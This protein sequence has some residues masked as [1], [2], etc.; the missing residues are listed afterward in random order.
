MRAN[1]GLSWCLHQL[2]N[3][4]E[5][6]IAQARARTWRDWYQ[7]TE[8]ALRRRHPDAAMSRNALL[9]AISAL[10]GM[11]DDFCRRWLVIQDPDTI[12]LTKGIGGTDEAV[13]QALTALWWRAVV[14][15]PPAM[16]T[17]AAATLAR[18][19]N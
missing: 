4:D 5:L 13:A 2:E 6:N 3:T 1:S 14:G 15:P 19:I 11:I 8:R 18:G 7:R 9:F 12:Q 10:G 16:T 17:G